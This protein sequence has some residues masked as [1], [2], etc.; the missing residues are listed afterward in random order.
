MLWCQL[1][2][3]DLEGRMKSFLIPLV[4]GGHNLS[5]ALCL[6]CG[7]GL[8]LVFISIHASSLEGY[9]HIGPILSPSGPTLSCGRENGTKF[10]ISSQP[11]TYLWSYVRD[12]WYILS[13]SHKRGNNPFNLKDWVSKVRVKEGKFPGFTYFRKT[14]SSRIR[15]EGRRGS[16]FSLNINRLLLRFPWPYISILIP[17][18]E[19]RLFIYRQNVLPIV[20]YEVRWL[21]I[22]V[23]LLF[24]WNIPQRKKWISS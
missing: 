18:L 12:G 4:L 6:G 20:H 13:T 9:Y 5:Q 17:V 11:S 24:G 21:E 1:F 7:C 3:V 22:V 23:S 15:R 19:V 14:S 8:G 16:R 10:L 2:V